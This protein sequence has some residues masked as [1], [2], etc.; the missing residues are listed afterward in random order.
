MHPITLARG[1]GWY[2]APEKPG[3][4]A[5]VVCPALGREG[6]WSYRAMR[7]LASRLAA[8][9]HPTLRFDYP[10]TGAS[11]DLPDCE[12]LAGWRD[13]VHGAVDWLRT[14]TGH[15][16]VAMCGLRFGALLATDVASSRDD[17][18]AL[19][20][21]S[22]FLNGRTCVRE[23]RMAAFGGEGETVPEN[24][25]EVDGM[26]LPDAR[27][28]ALATLDLQTVTVAPAPRILVMDDG[29]RA[30]SFAAHL[31]TLGADTLVEGFPGYGAMMRVAT[32]NEVP[33]E[34]FAAVARWLAP[35]TG[36]APVR[37][38]VPRRVP[39]AGP[40]WREQAVQFGPGNRLAGTLCCA[41][42]GLDG[43]QA[44]IIPNTGGDGRFGIARF[45]VHLAHRL[46]AAGIASLRFDFAG[47]GDSISPAE[48]EGHVYQTDRSGDIGAALAY[49]E[50]CGY[51]RVS[52][53]GLCT[54]AYHLLHAAGQGARLE[55]LALINLVTFQWRPGDV[56]D[57]PQRP[58][59][60]PLPTAPVVRLPRPNGP[61]M[62]WDDPAGAVASMLARSKRLL[63]LYGPGDAGWAAL[64]AAFG[65]GGRA[66]AASPGA[67]LRLEPGIDHTLSRRAMQDRVAA[68]VLAFMQ[69]G[70]RTRVTAATRPSGAFHPPHRS[71]TLPAEALSPP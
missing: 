30:A 40:G 4:V 44:V 15:A 1:Y 66:L 34:A 32:A 37:A 20:L 63:F 38:S 50:D 25:I 58:P 16:R 60:G 53:V 36:A 70:N 21:L 49:L 56:V 59:G 45:G 17:I 67:T 19:A 31:Q 29:K 8:A 65:P 10:G 23:L 39:L 61:V 33:Q 64:E 24:G 35:E 62:P 18:A 13:R 22:P 54:G 9:G 26:F 41:A 47:L 3:G 6:R 28:A 48:A 12:P 55:R 5:V 43:P 68:A 69:A 71:D 27:L 46:A 51:A 11:P 2:H 14:Q 57:V 42:A 7:H 52:G